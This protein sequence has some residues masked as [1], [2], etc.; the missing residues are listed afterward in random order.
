MSR[1]ERKKEET[2]LNILQTALDLFRVKGFQDTSMEEIAE[3]T[4]ISKGTLYNYFESKEAILSAYIQTTTA[5]FGQ[6]ME[7][8]LNK[9]QGVESRL[10]LLLNFKHDLLGKDLELTAIYLSYRMQTL[11]SSPLPGSPFTRPFSNPS[12]ATQRSGLENVVIKIISDAQQNKEIRSDLPVLV[13][14]RSFQLMSINYFLF[15]QSAN[16]SSETEQLREQLI[17]LFLN[18]AKA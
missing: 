1:R 6:E 5:N 2:R 9:H 3:S 12:V 11:F 8:L 7:S 16:D 10:R 15:C 14:A 17:E 4:D 18:G 13:L